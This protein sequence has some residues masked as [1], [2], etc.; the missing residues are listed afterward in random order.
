ML[1]IDLRKVIK[2]IAGFIWLLHYQIAFWGGSVWCNQKWVFYMICLSINSNNNFQK[3]AN[4]NSCKINNRIALHDWS[5]DYLVTFYNMIENT[6]RLLL[7][8]NI[9]CGLYFLFFF[10]YALHTLQYQSICICI[11]PFYCDL[12][13]FSIAMFLVFVLV[14][15]YIK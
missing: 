1:A 10:C 4:L 11:S 14:E 7:N 13:I 2:K 9:Q 15:K 5:L 6:D 12:L 8:F 3:N